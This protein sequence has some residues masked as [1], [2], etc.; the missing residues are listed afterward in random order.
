MTLTHRRVNPALLDAYMARSAVILIAVAVLA[1]AGLIE[2]VRSNRFGVPE[3]ARAAAAK[4]AGIPREVGPWVATEAPMDDRVVAQAEAVGHLS[5][6]YMHRRTG[7]EV[8][9]LI[10]CGPAGPLGSHT[11]DICYAGRG[12]TQVGRG[13]RKTLALPG[14][15]VATYWSARFEKDGP[16]E[17]PLEV[18]WAWGTDGD[19][20]ASANPRGEFAFRSV[21]Y[22]LYVT[23]RATDPA[24][25][26]P[27]DP[28]AE[29]LTAFLPE[30]KQALAPHPGSPGRTT[31]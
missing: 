15:G 30:T 11:P 23:R 21:L 9:V 26:P 12:Y 3:D 25:Q 7:A 24:D 14:G 18:C 13:V 22:K 27:A 1:A 19:W 16:G 8:N 17:T 6:V 28:V 29:F 20:S 4:L 5:R 2:G 10:L 31:P